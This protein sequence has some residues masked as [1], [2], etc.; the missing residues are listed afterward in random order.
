MTV[1]LRLLLSSAFAMLSVLSLAA[2]A[3]SVSLQ[4]DR[5]TRDMV[6]NRFENL[7][8]VNALAQEHWRLLD[9]AQ[10]TKAQLLLWDEVKKELGESRERLANHWR[11]VQQQPE[12]AH[13]YS[14]VA[15]EREAVSTFLDLMA[16]KVDAQSYYEFGRL[17]DFKLYQ[18]FDPM[19]SRI[20]EQAIAEQ[21]SARA[22]AAQLLSHL[23]DQRTW[24][25][26]GVMMVLAVLL[27]VM[28]WLRKAVTVRLGQI[29]EALE[30]ID[31][32]AN[33]RHKLP[34][35]GHDEV[36]AVARATN[37]LISRFR[38]FVCQVGN[39][40][41]L[42]Q[43][44]AIKLDQQAEVVTAGTDRI[45]HQIAA[46]VRSVDVMAA[47]A[48]TIQRFMDQTRAKV[49]H[50]V[51]GNRQADDILEHAENASQS[52]VEAITRVV[53]I[54]LSLEGSSS[55]ITQV[56][57]VIEAIADQTNLLALNAA[58]EAA[59]A[60]EQGRGFSV[61][62]DEVRALAKRTADS[63]SEIR[64]WIT[65]LAD[66]VVSVRQSLTVTE[67][68][69]ESNQKATAALRHYLDTMQDTFLELQVVSDQVSVAVSEQNGEI[70]RVQEQASALE[71]GS[72]RL[73]T[74]AAST[75]GIGE[76]LKTQAASLS[77]KI[78]E[79]DA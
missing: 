69:G 8:R 51:E 30:D 11:N 41:A 34:E 57:D 71:Q 43:Q 20:D 63:T 37:G 28:F 68:A 45:Q 42:L 14:Q 21:A 15:P 61:V 59:R 31:R 40:T 22:S 27:A 23:A 66:H 77:K 25:A 65:E 48:Q 24:L 52:S 29:S 55:R 79:F 64:E 1:R 67:Q 60:G 76:Q 32:T 3:L 74:T 50:A 38:S 9:L 47:S 70:R 54:M 73:S 19:L 4:A 78:S 2:L 17:V 62:A 26:A 16:E 5:S 36:H 6:E 12:L 53:K 18:H 13:W 10:K 35:A 39:E 56:M 33:L 46:A 75:H 58:I 72:E 49:L 44:Q 7:W